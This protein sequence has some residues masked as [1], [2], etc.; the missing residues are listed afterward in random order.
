MP[1]N[2]ADYAWGTNGRYP[3]QTTRIHPIRPSRSA[4][5]ACCSTMKGPSG[6]VTRNRCPRSLPVGDAVALEMHQ[7]LDLV[8]LLEPVLEKQ[9]GNRVTAAGLPVSAGGQSTKVDVGMQQLA[10]PIGVLLSEGA[11]C[12][13]RF[14]KE[15]TPSMQPR[16]ELQ[17]PMQTD[18]TRP[19]HRGRRRLTPWLIMATS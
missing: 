13:A 14:P 16:Y 3:E 4:R 2:T 5:Y 8:G 17:I 10:H 1:S 11:S 18:N 12:Q 19:L 7:L 15:V 6:Q 9:R